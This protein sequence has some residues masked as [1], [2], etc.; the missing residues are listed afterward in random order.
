[1]KNAI[2][3]LLAIAF[4]PWVRAAVNFMLDE[5]WKPEVDLLVVVS[6]DPENHG[7]AMPF[8]RRQMTAEAAIERARQAAQ[9]VANRL[10]ICPR[11][12]PCPICTD[13]EARA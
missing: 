7:M 11:P 5:A 1:M 8:P 10:H 13:L 3:L 2:R 12:E 4:R 9:S 6:A